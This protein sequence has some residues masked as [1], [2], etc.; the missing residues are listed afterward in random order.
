MPARRPTTDRWPR[1]WGWLLAA[2]LSIVLWIIIIAALVAI[3]RIVG[4]VIQ[5]RYG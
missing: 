2:A 5:A 3:V 4:E 1:A